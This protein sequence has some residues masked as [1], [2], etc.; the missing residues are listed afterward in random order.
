MKPQDIVVALEILLHQKN[1]WTQK[2]LAASLGIS[3]SEISQS[4]NRLKYCGLML[5]EGQEVM[6]LA[7]FDFIQYAIKFVFPSKP[8]SMVRGIPTS[9]AAPPLEKLINSTEKYVWPYAKGSVRG[10]A[11]TPLYSSIPGIIDKNPKLYELLA[12]IDAIRVGNKREQHIAT[13]EMQKRIVD[14]E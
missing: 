14:G 9:H 7:L 5:D 11:I 3:Q 4:I 8:G 1:G 10:Q 2:G 13:I 6:R 12:L